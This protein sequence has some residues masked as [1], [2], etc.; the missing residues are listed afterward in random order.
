MIGVKIGTGGSTGHAYLKKTAEGLKKTCEFLNRMARE[1]RTT[2]FVST[3]PQTKM[4]FKELQKD[5]GYPIV[6]NKWVGGML[7]NLKTISGRIRK[8]KNIREMFETGEIEKFTKKEQSKMK[9]EMDKLEI[10]FGGIEKMHKKPDVMF[11]IDGKR[12][13]NAIREANKLNI[14]VVGICDSN[15]DPDNYSILIPANDDAISSL[16]HILSFI[17][18]AVKI[19]KKS[20]K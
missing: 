5:T 8:L 2:L 15:V 6:I 10:A 20:N 13:I 7:T 12:D 14:P 9:K 4:L 19:G 18:D 16:T 11:V 3:K 1:G 17:F